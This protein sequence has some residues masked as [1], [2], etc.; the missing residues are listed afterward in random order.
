MASSLASVQ[1]RFRIRDR[2]EIPRP[3]LPETVNLERLSSHKLSGSRSGTELRSFSCR[4]RTTIFLKKTNSLFTLR[5]VNICCIE[6]LLMNTNLSSPL[7]VKL[8][9]KYKGDDILGSHNARKTTITRRILQKKLFS[10]SPLFVIRKKLVLF[11]TY[12]ENLENSR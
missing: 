9:W 3:W 6:N 7:S 2:R 8:G 1:L 4:G 10:L 5:H 12:S 11:L